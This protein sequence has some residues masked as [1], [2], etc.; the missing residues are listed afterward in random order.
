MTGNT[1]VA[2]AGVV[3]I[4]FAES[5]RASVVLHDLCGLGKIEAD[6]FDQVT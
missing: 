3:S 4:C 5:Y 1:E 2:G 6:V